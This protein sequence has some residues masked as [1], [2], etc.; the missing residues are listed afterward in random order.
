[1]FVSRLR[2]YLLTEESVSI[3]TVRGT[4]LIFRLRHP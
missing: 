3:E 1:V 2:K 4:G